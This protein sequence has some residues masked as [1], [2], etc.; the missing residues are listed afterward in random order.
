MQNMD[1]QMMAEKGVLTCGFNPATFQ[2]FVDLEDLAAVAQ[3][4]L[5]D[6]IS[7]NRARYDIVGHNCT[8]EDV[9]KT[10]EQVTGKKVKCTQPPREEVV[11]HGFVGA[12]TENAYAADALERMLYYY[13]KRCV[14]A[15]FRACLKGGVDWCGRG[16]PGSANTVRWVLGREPT[17]WEG[18]IRRE[19]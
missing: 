1:I 6:P 10:F 12:K 5:L 14:S 17:T 18:F 7:H 13:D 16:I 9:A 2:G 15:G 8:L 3:V 11:K 19:T 4:V